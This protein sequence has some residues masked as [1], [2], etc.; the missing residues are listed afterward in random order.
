MSQNT[1]AVK[2]YLNL[3]QKISKYTAQHMEMI[4]STTSARTCSSLF[5]SSWPWP[6]PSQNLP[7]LHGSFSLLEQTYR[8][9]CTQ[10]EK[11]KKRKKKVKLGETTYQNM[12]FW[13]VTY[14]RSHLRI[15]PLLDLQWNKN[16]EWLD[17]TITMVYVMLKC[18]HASTVGISLLNCQVSPL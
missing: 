5:L 15:C 8:L 7:V 18:L 9:L 10:P 12:S 4:T 13:L 6:L 1:S 14:T 17:P 2:D 11:T 3:A 16:S